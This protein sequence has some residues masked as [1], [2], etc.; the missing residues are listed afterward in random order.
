MHNNR[1]R[2]VSALR[3]ARIRAGLS[4]AELDHLAGVNPA[5]VRRLEASPKVKHVCLTLLAAALT[6][7]VPEGVIT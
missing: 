7:D 2:R 6:E 4:Q 1:N 3:C 5:T